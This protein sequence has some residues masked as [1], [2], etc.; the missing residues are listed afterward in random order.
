MN[1]RL[2]PQNFTR[3]QRF[4]ITTTLQELVLDDYRD[5]LR[6]DS[7]EQFVELLQCMTNLTC[8]K[9]RSVNGIQQ[10]SKLT[11][12]R[13]LELGILQDPTE[14]IRLTALITLTNLQSFTFEDK[15]HDVGAVFNSFL[16]LEYL[17]LV[18][19]IGMKDSDFSTLSD[20]SKLTRLEISAPR[21]NLTINAL[22]YLTCLT[23]LTLTYQVRYGEWLQPEERPANIQR[24]GHKP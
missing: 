9:V 11:S 8:L 15:L 20:L 5:H 7:W 17:H 23:N 1:D 12:L 2:D 13:C 22:D 3:L 16:N 21:F 14:Q 10:L 4:A 18:N 19:V 6:P 24:V